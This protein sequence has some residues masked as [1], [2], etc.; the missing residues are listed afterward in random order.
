MS[1]SDT[2]HIKHNIYINPLNPP[3]TKNETIEKKPIEKNDKPKGWHKDKNHPEYFTNIGRALRFKDSMVKQIL[4]ITETSTNIQSTKDI[5]QWLS[6]Y[7]LP[8]EFSQEY[9]DATGD[10]VEIIENK[11]H[12]KPIYSWGYFKKDFLGC[13][14]KYFDR[15]EVQNVL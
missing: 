9:Y 12:P 1:P 11:P 2:E 13:M 5:V 15:K 8:Q 6:L 7:D 4:K 14:D 3:Q 10:F